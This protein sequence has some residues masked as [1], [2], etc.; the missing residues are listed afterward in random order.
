LATK[1]H[2]RKSTPIWLRNDAETIV[3]PQI[4]PVVAR[5]MMA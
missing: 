1:N 3:S 5:K 4:I 2:G